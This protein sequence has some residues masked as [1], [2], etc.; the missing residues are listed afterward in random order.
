[1]LGKE[2]LGNAMFGNAILGNAILGNAILERA[3]GTGVGSKGVPEEREVSVI[4]GV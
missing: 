4:V 2:I 1:V 3:K